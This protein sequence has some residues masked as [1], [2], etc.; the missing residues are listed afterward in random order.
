MPAIFASDDRHYR[1]WVNILPG[2]L[3]PGS[4]QYLSGRRRAAWLWFA[5]TM[6]AGM[7]IV[8]LLLHPRSGYQWNGFHWADAVCIA[9]QLAIALDA[10]RRPIPRM[11]GAGWGLFLTVFLALAVLPAMVIRQFIVHPFK[12][13]TGAMQ[14]TIQGITFRPAPAGDNPGAARALLG[15]GETYRE[16]RATARGRIGPR[17]RR[18]AGEDVFDIG[19]APHAIQRGL[20]LLVHPGEDV[21][22]GQLL[23]AGIEKQ[24]DHILVNKTAYWFHP[25]QRGDIVVFSTSGLHSPLVRTH[26]YYVKR[27]V[28][29]PGET[30][31]IDPP[32]VVADGSKLLDPPILRAIAEERGGFRLAE[33]HSG[34]LLTKP[35]DSIALGPDEYLVLGDNT[36]ASLDGRYY[37]P[38]ARSAIVGKVVCIYSPSDRRGRVQ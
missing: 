10:L 31:S 33:A 36:T 22:R 11:G 6:L 37:G 35:V 24:G 3:I 5:A 28:G 20:T 8:A 38:L 14:P 15:P 17:P 18:S 2:I 30:V 4:A 26:T 16:V 12:V 34:G 19:G 21:Q 1:R 27:I 9:L 13:P 32:Y 25:P 23:A 29:L 7:G